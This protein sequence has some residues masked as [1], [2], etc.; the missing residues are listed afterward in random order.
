MQHYGMCLV[1]ENEPKQYASLLLREDGK[2]VVVVNDG[3]VIGD[4]VLDARPALTVTPVGAGFLADL[5]REGLAQLE[6]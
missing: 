1:D 2:L 6:D 5:L 4:D 3:T